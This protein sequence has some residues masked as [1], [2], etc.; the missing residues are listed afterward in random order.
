MRE[1]ALLVV[2]DH[3]LV[4]DVVGVACSSRT[5]VTLERLLRE[6]VQVDVGA[7]AGV[8]GKRRA[9]QRG[10]NCESSRIMRSAA[11]RMSR[12]FCVRLSP[13]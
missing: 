11:R 1:D 4:L 5:P 9:D 8:A 7:L 10:R 3:A 6:D 2:L 12:R 13:S